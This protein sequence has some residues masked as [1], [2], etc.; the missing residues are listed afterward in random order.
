M[1]IL[2]GER[3]QQPV[4]VKAGSGQSA[5]PSTVH[6]ACVSQKK[7]QRLYQTSVQ[8][9]KKQRELTLTH[10]R[11]ALVLH[12]SH[13]KSKDSPLAVHSLPAQHVAPPLSAGG[14]A[15]KPQRGT[16]SQMEQDKRSTGKLRHSRPAHRDGRFNCRTLAF[17][18][19]L[20]A[21]SVRFGYQHL[22][23]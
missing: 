22:C 15:L 8:H 12:F 16:I 1:E 6:A 21:I 7:F 5:Q 17:V 14:I 11:C 23:K 18:H 13:L 4:R 2:P 9:P 20:V 19:S 10:E 3:C